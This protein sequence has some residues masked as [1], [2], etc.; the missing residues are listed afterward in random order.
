MPEGKGSIV[1]NVIAKMEPKLV[2]EG[3][4]QGRG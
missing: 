3:Y 1:T 4:E 2:N